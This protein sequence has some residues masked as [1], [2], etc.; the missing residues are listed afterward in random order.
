[1]QFFY[2]IGLLALAG[3][4]IPLI[5][6]LWNIKQG[7]TLKIGSISLLG[8]SSRA[9]S[10]SFKI[11]DWLLFVLRCLL[12]ILIGFCIAEPYLSK[13][14][15]SKEKGGWILVDKLNFKSAYQ[16]NKKTIDSLLKIRYQIHDFN[17][18]F[19]ALNLEDTIANNQTNT[20]P[21]YTSLF[22][23]L[24]QTLPS[25]TNVFVYQN[26]QQNNFGDELPKTQFNIHWNFLNNSDSMKTWVTDFAGKKLEAKSTPEYTTYEKLNNQNPAPIS[27]AIYNEAS[28]N[29]DKY[30]NAALNAISD[31]SKRKI[32]LNSKG[33]NNQIGFWL[34]DK[35]ITSN[36]KSSIIE[37]GTLFK[38][39]SGKAE[40]IHSF[41][42]I[43]GKDIPLSKRINIKNQ[44]SNL[45]VDGFGNSLLSKEN[46][47]KLTIL[48]F[49]TRLN[50][51]WNELVWNEA[52]LKALMPIVLQSEKSKTFGFE[53]NLNDQRTLQAN[54]LTQEHHDLKQKDTEIVIKESIINYFWIA[55][56]II[57]L[58]ERILSFRN[59]IDDA[60]N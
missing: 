52:F 40:S 5:I 6:H 4:I 35:P 50:P 42:Q 56:L 19:A 2:P 49:Y 26:L 29:D 51:Q 28:N 21:N 12:I 60:K 41:I 18:G 45:W 33:N 55:A 14:L 10:K 57:F 30:L 46:S 1:M 3:L 58:T 37:N 13:K 23:Q 32:V 24:N 9:S 48:S 34:S 59:K 20:N 8:E 47:G 39:A 43:E 31:F 36:F 15:N 27:V 22:N 7:K 54:Q 38:Y 16:Q 44:S 25:G 17:Y 53:D 11:A